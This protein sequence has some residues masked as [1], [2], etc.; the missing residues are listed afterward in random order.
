MFLNNYLAVSPGRRM[1][2][3]APGVSAGEETGRK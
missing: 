1:F 3:K 2:Q